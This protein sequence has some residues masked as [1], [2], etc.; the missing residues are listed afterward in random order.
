MGDTVICYQIEIATPDSDG[1][2]N[3]LRVR[4]R[5]ECEEAEGDTEFDA[6][7]AVVEKRKRSRIESAKE[8]IEDLRRELELLGRNA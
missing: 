6:M 2:R 3:G 8:E 7:I 4:A 1:R 5:F